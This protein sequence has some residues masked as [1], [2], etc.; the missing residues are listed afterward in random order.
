MD[1][2]NTTWVGTCVPCETESEWSILTYDHK[3]TDI[4]F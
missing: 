4:F 3:L 1:Q 2:T